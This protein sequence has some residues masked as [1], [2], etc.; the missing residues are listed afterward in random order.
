MARST[1][2]GFNPPF[3]RAGRVMPVQTD[4]RLIKNDL[5]QL[6]L[7]APGERVFRPDFG[8][9]LRKSTFEPMDTFTVNSIK[10]SMARTIAQFE[11]RVKTSEIIIE[12]DDVNSQLNIHVFAALTIDPN[13]ILELNISIPIGPMATPAPPGQLAV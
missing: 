6:L 13:R 10:T 5:L 1:Y 2:F 4:E 3:F 9:A 7:T 8:T 11:P 12:R